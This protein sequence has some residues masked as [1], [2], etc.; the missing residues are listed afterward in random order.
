MSS[1]YLVLL[2]IIL[3]DDLYKPCT[4]TDFDS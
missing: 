1:T 4:L 2:W 3:I